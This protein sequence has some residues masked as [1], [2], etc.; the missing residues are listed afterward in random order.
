MLKWFRS[1]SVGR[2]KQ[3]FL[4][5]LRR[6]R[7]DLRR[8][9]R[10]WLYPVPCI[11]ALVGWIYVFIS[12]GRSASIE[13]DLVWTALGIIAYL[14]WAY[15]EGCGRPFRMGIAISAPTQRLREARSYSFAGCTWPRSLVCYSVRQSPSLAWVNNTL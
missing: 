5:V 14:I 11:I 9:Y 15:Y 3:V 1:G 6:K 8:S 10:Q 7:P 4:S 12:F 2:G 13:L